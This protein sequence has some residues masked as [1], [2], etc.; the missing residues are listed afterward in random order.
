MTGRS[1]QNKKMKKSDQKFRLGLTSSIVVVLVLT[2]A[3]IGN[4]LVGKLN[5]SWDLSQE[6]VYTISD[7]TKSIL[8]FLKYKKAQE[9]EAEG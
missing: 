2:V 7:Q 4:L 6:G 3:I 1:G 8:K 5:L 9:G